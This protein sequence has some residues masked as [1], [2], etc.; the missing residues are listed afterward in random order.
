MLLSVILDRI[1][2]C[3]SRRRYSRQR[4]ALDLSPQY[5]DYTFGPFIHRPADPSIVA[6]HRIEYIDTFKVAV[7]MLPYLTGTVPFRLAQTVSV[8]GTTPP[9]A[10]YMS[11]WWDQMQ[12]SCLTRVHWA[13]LSECADDSATQTDVRKYSFHKFFGHV[14]GYVRTV[15]LTYGSSTITQLWVCITLYDSQN[16]HRHRH[17]R[18]HRVCYCKND[19]TL[20]APACASR[21][22]WLSLTW[23]V[24]Q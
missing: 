12:M 13:V 7:E 17:H 2:I 18:D 8:T 4:S 10:A 6:L 15:I 19:V 14:H 21:I 5:L 16:I 22:F 20:R 1:C 9:T 24:C 3:L 11:S 23:F